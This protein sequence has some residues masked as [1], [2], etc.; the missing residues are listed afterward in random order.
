MDVVS[1]EVNHTINQN[2]Y[3]TA[4]LQILTDPTSTRPTTGKITKYEVQPFAQTTTTGSASKSVVSTAVQASR[5]VHIEADVVSG[6][7]VTNHVVWTQ[8]LSYSNV[9]TYRQNGSVQVSN[10]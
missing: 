8:S 10:L 4:N 7:G 2:W 5:S 9:Q 6:S 1:A 3:L